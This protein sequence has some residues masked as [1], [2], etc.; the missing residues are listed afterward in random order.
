[1]MSD[2][3]EKWRKR[4]EREKKSRCAAEQLL[5]EKSRELYD[6]NKK[7][8]RKY[9][10]IFESSLDGLFLHDL[11]GRILEVNETACRMLGSS[12]EKLVGRPI[13]ELHPEEAAS[14]SRAAMRRVSTEGHCRFEVSF[15]RADGSL[16]PAEVS[17]T[18]FELEGRS[19]VQG[20]VHDITDRKRVLAQIRR[21]K[22]E[23]ERAN[24]AK[25]LFLATMSHEIRTPLNGIIG[26]TDLLLG[27]KTL[28]GQR[29]KLEVIRH[30]GDILLA[31]I[32]DILDF[33]RIESGRIQFEKIA[34]SPAICIRE[35]LDLHGPAAFEKAVV[36]RSEIAD[37]VPE[38]IVGDVARL[39]QVLMNLVANA[40]K[41]TTEGEVVVRCHPGEG[42]MLWFSVKDTGAGFDP[43]EAEKLF[44]PFY[45][46]D[47]STTRRFGGTGLG[48]AVCR[49]LL[50]KMGGGIRAIGEPG[51][52]ADFQFYIPLV[53][54]E[55]K[56]ARA[57]PP[58]LHEGAAGMALG[59]NRVVLLAEDNPI[60]AELARLV[61][62]RMGLRSVHAPDGRQ[63]LKLLRG[64]GSYDA[65]LMDVRMPGMDGLEATRRIRRGEAG[66]GVREI[67]II[68]LTASAMPADEAACYDAGMSAYVSKPLRPE[69]VAAALGEAGLLQAP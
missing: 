7:L 1:M 18:R 46:E 22:E 26:F 62:E 20:L 9:Q 30:S 56:P 60:N 55:A 39:R 17:A 16:L 69:E 61:L 44:E 59:G 4:Y 15:R 8:E 28:E 40:L 42:Q 29:D 57:E 58:L 37:D 19:V 27:E 54:A 24:E 2:E 53:A 10:L 48:L 23:A 14:V 3:V 50:E 36:L 6:A 12:R 63:V 67:P 65:V 49:G 45:Q 47:A 33:S 31:I 34:F 43:D 35:V 32:N 64:E 51:K 11:D 5:E 52:G 21:A 68:A 38:M 25:S 41:F 13:Q 66:E